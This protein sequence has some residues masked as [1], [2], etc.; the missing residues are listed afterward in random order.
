[1]QSLKTYWLRPYRRRHA[2]ISETLNTYTTV[3]EK[4]KVISAS[5]LENFYKGQTEGKNENEQNKK[6]S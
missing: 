2:D 1:K 3:L 6:Q 5:K 4:H